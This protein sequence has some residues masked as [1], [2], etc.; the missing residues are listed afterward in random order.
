MYEQR[1]RG[2]EP[3][4]TMK[5]PCTITH[6]EEVDWGASTNSDQELDECKDKKYS[7]K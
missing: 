5:S 6:E 1:G 3:T 7:F 2:G 4:M